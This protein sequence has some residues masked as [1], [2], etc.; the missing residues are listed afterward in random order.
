VEIP[1][2]RDDFLGNQSLQ[3]Q[4]EL[5]ATKKISKY[6][7]GS[8]L[9]EHIHVLVEPP[10][11]IAISNREQ[12]LLDRIASLDESLNKSEVPGIYGM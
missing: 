3:D 4:T 10:E 5:L 7:P 1:D 2:D 8:P 6:F 11:V 9:E 12:E